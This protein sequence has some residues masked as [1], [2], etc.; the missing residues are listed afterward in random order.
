MRSRRGTIFLGKA[1][2]MVY[3][4]PSRTTGV[5]RAASRMA[6]ASVLTSSGVKPDGRPR[7]D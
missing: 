4:R 6:S 3:A 1:T 2:R 7:W 5:Q